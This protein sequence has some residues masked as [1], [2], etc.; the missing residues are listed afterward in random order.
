[1]LTRE[2]VTTGHSANVQMSLVVGDCEFSVAQSGIGYII[3]ESPAMHPPADAVFI[4]TIDGDEKRRSIR[5][6]Q[7]IQQEVRR[8]PIAKAE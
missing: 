7:G 8:T 6:P 2:Q 1:M 5:L 3:L 4:V